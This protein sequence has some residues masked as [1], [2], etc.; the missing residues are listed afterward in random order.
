M[1]RPRFVS[2]PMST[3]H[4]ALQRVVAFLVDMSLW[5]ALAFGSVA[6]F[7][8]QAL[9]LGDDIAPALLVGTSSLAIYLLDHLIDARVQPI[10][11]EGLQRLF[12]RGGPAVLFL[13]ALGATVALTIAAPPAARWVL[14][15]Y[16]AVGFSYGVPLFPGRR[17]GRPHLYR[18]KDTPGMK[19]VIVAGAV[20]VST[21]G[22]PL[23]YAGVPLGLEACTLG[24]FIFT[25]MF[26]NAVLFDVRDLASD[27]A[28][29]VPTLP[30]LLGF[31]RTR[32]LLLAVSGVV[33]LA[34]VLMAAPGA[35]LAAMLLSLGAN[36][37]WVLAV[38]PSTKRRV[39]GTFI[40]GTLAL[41]A[42][43]LLLQLA[44]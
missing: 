41:P 30:V 31:E 14:F 32:T 21:V 34:L 16:I 11:D 38:T 3:L 7:V 33:A 43:L 17:A 28:G 24:L 25:L 9:G 36:V 18:L 10:P 5:I 23:A 37:A 39:Y 4:S 15:A 22:I 42:L 40:D 20:V 29:H 13:C 44:P 6:W 27:R 1:S 2:G 8:Q 12:R 35:P 19:A 26:T